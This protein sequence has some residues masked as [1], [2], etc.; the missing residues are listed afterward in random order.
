MLSCELRAD[1][2]YEK[3]DRQQGVTKTELHVGPY[4]RLFSR[5]HQ[6][7]TSSEDMQFD[8]IQQLSPLSK[9]RNCKPEDLAL[10]S[11]AALSEKHRNHRTSPSHSF[12]PMEDREKVSQDFYR[13][14]SFV[15]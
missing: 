4:V 2:S 14:G 13:N 1:S 12:L 11:P 9:E 15:Q 10:L 3:E 6:D 8:N 7:E 5:H